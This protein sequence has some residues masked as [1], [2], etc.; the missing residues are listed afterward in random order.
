MKV[1]LVGPIGDVPSAS[2]HDIA[3]RLRTA[4]VDVDVHNPATDELVIDY[5]AAYNP[6]SKRETLLPF[7]LLGRLR[8]FRRWRRKV[9]PVLRPYGAVLVWDPLIATM[10]RFARPP[11]TRIVWTRT[12]P[13]VDDA[14][15]AV[16]ARLARATCDRTVVAGEDAWFDEV[17][18]S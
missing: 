1:L 5:P 18:R 3:A 17:V 16:L 2:A 10:L 13:A 9:R 15:N 7:F 11:T 8:A 14:W 12:P 4:G 6:R